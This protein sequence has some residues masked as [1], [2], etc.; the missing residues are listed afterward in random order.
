[1]A[2]AYVD[3]FAHYLRA[4]EIDSSSW[5][6]VLSELEASV[7]ISQ[8]L[9]P[10]A[11]NS[12]EHR[13]LDES[14]VGLEELGFAPYSVP[15]TWFR[16]LLKTELS[17]VSTAADVTLLLPVSNVT[18][19]RTLSVHV[20]RDVRATD[21]DQAFVLVNN[22]ERS[23]YHS[24]TER[25]PQLFAYAMMQLD[26]PIVSRFELTDFE[27][28]M[29]GQ[30]GIDHESIILD[31]P[32]DL[33]IGTALIPQTP[34]L[35]NVFY[36]AMSQLPTENSSSGR[37]LYIKRSTAAASALLNEDDVESFLAEIGRSRALSHGVW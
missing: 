3:E 8:W 18:N 36:S 6:R 14:T 9:N 28:Y 12:E 37:K 13:N 7:K 17:Q 5:A 33:S 25:L 21:V 4:Q 1:L 20:L 2:Y 35:A 27:K 32:G 15:L 34:G 16:Q 30:F 10:I 26:C 19:I 24:I 29:A 22:E 23:F 11:S 31:L